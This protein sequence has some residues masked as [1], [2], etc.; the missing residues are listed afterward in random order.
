MQIG[1]RGG[2][3]IE[4]LDSKGIVVA[5]KS[6]HVVVGGCELNGSTPLPCMSNYGADFR[7]AHATSV[8]LMYF[9]IG[10][11]ADAQ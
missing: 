7:I 11:I 9:H 10:C 5:Q 3:T 8:A 2:E 6:K 1:Y 4:P